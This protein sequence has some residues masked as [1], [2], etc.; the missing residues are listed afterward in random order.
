MGLKHKSLDV[1]SW[2][3]LFWRWD[4]VSLTLLH[5][6]SFFIGNFLIYLYS[7]V[8][9][10]KI[11]FHSGIVPLTS[12]SKFFTG[13]IL[14]HAH[15]Q[16]VYYNCVKFHLNPM[17]RLGGVALTSKTLWRPLDVCSWLVYFGDGMLSPWHYSISVLFS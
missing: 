17:S 11:L 14:L 9:T 4:V 7:K 16:A 12:P 6:R 5:N 13:T 8:W 15:L 3:S 2:L 10:S 1:C